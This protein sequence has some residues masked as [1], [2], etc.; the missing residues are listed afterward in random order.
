MRIDE[1]L[2]LVV[3][4]PASFLEQGGDETEG[5]S[6]VSSRGQSTDSLARR[7]AGSDLDV[8]GETST[9]V[10]PERR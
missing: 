3:G 9:P 4:R 7:K 5:K 1:I 10:L 2:L 8:Y 6:N